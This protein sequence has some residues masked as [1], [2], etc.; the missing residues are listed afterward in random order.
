MKIF[1]LQWIPEKACL[2]LGYDVYDI[3]G[4]EFQHS[5]ALATLYY[6]ITESSFR[7]ELSTDLFE[8]QPEPI[9][10][11]ENPLD[12]HIYFTELISEW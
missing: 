9:I 10:H 11:D 8:T 2:L 1:S 3:E 4:S 7:M 12:Q 6:S 5:M